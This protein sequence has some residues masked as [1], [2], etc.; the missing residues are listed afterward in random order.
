[1][2]GGTGRSRTCQ[3]GKAQWR[4]GGISPSQRLCPP[5]YFRDASHFVQNFLK[6]CTFLFF[7]TG[8]NFLKSRNFPK[9]CISS[10]AFPVSRGEKCKNQSFLANCD[11]CPLDSP[12]K[13]SYATIGNAL[14][15]STIN[16]YFPSSENGLYRY[17][18][19]F[20]T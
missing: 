10:V 4:Q 11:F 6:K 1:M 3:I 15:K 8:L 14:L 18:I 12:T 17:K 13:N 16:T 2:R 19:V 5:T 9:T 20:S 7:C